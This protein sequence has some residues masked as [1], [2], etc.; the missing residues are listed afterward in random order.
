MLKYLQYYN[1]RQDYIPSSS[2]DCWVDHGLGLHHQ[3]ILKSCKALAWRYVTSPEPDFD[4]PH[5]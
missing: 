2:P 1:D 4:S 5:P 3:D